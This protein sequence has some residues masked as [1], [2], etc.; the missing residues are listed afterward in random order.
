MRARALALSCSWQE[1]ELMEFDFQAFGCCSLEFILEKVEIRVG[2]TRQ[3][4]GNTTTSFTARSNVS[5]KTSK[6][7]DISIVDIQSILQVILAQH[8]VGAREKAF[9]RIFPARDRIFGDSCSCVLSAL[10]QCDFTCPS[11]VHD[12]VLCRCDAAVMSFTNA[13]LL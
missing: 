2:A 9:K 12:P 6:L 10:L 4:Q 8:A 11:V 3:M 13:V 1:W 7:K 5:F